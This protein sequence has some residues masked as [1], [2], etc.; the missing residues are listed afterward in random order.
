MT[1]FCRYTAVFCDFCLPVSR[2]AIFE[3]IDY[4][5]FCIPNDIMIRRGNYHGG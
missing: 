3:L 1:A 4:N 5:M 2:I